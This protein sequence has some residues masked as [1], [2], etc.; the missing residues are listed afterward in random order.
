[1]SATTRPQI[2]V[3][4]GSPGVQ[5]AVAEGGPTVLTLDSLDGVFSCAWSIESTDETYVAGQYTLVTSGTKNETVTISATVDWPGSTAFFLGTAAI[6][7][8]T[9]NGGV[10]PQTGDVSEIMTATA[11]FYVLTADGYEVG[12]A[13]EK[14]ETD[15]TFGSLP[16]LNAVIRNAGTAGALAVA[17]IA[18]GDP[19]T[20]LV[21]DSLYVVDTSGAAVPDL[22]MPAAP[23]NGA[24]VVV[25]DG[26]GSAS[27]NNI[28]VV[29]NTGQ[30]IEDPNAP[31]TY[32]G[33]A[34]TVLISAD[35][36]S[37]EFV[38]IDSYAS[39]MVV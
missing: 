21:A 31:G 15:A 16:L 12:C 11:K 33:V 25:K 27:G 14:L 19:P 8:A 2:R 39:W 5:G 34:G 3:D 37:V 6:V 32:A 7:L 30:N 38:W 18:D 20:T 29:G 4:G 1:M 10:D 17:F 35:G 28:P 9:V 26:R 23:T 13:D 22:T 36:G 24:R